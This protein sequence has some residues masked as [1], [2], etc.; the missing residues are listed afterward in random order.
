MART[1]HHHFQ[2]V[3][4]TALA[5]ALGKVIGQQAA[6]SGGKPYHESVVVL[7]DV[8]VSEIPKKMFAIAETMTS[9]STCN[10]PPQ[11]W[12]LLSNFFTSEKTGEP[13]DGVT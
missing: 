4:A 5:V 8:F 6:N 12:G 11:M 1:Q 9:R 2:R 13:P 10:I 7:W 3:V